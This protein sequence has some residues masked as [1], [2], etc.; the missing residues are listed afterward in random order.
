MDPA[1]SL[2]RPRPTG[3]ADRA[4]PGSRPPAMPSTGARSPAPGAIHQREPRARWHRPAAPWALD[5]GRS[6]R[7][8]GARSGGAAGADRPQGSGGLQVQHLDP[9]VVF[10]Q[11][12]RLL[13][14]FD[15]P[16]MGHNSCKYL[17]TLTECTK[18]A[19]ADREAFYGDPEFDSVPLEN[20]L[21]QSTPTSAAASSAPPPPWNCGR[22]TWGA[23]SP[24]TSAS[25]SLMTTAAPWACQ[26]SGS[27]WR[28]APAI[29]PTSMRPTPRAT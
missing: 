8:A 3:V 2:W 21:H 26:S 16:A 11:Q 1:A 29:P 14:G 6:R 18:L 10:Q 25:M 28:P 22:A 27:P 20:L 4:S 9:G 23:A 17:H 15:L 12:L 7:V 13:G 5:P 19:F 24:T